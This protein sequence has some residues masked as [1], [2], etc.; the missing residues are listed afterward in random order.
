M[1]TTPVRTEAQRAVI[2]G[3]GAITPIGNSAGE[4]WDGL[5]AGR[6]GAGPITLFDASPNDVRIAAEVKGFV[7]LLLAAAR[8]LNH[9]PGYRYH[10]AQQRRLRSNEVHY[11]DHPQFGIIIEIRPAKAARAL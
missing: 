5:I 9:E 7:A 10:M 8:G 6:S 1:S 3:Y 11:L 4:Y 2:T